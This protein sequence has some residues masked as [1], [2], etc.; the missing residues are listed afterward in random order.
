MKIG[1]LDH[2]QIGE[3]KTAAIALAESVRLAQETER[4]GYGRFWVSEHHGSKALAA[5][6]PE[7]MIAHLAAATSRIRVG[8]GGIMLTH[9]SAYKVAENFRLLEA[10]HP[11]RIDLGLGR[12]PGGMPIATRAL[13]EGKHYHIDQY[14]QQIAD[15][16]AYLH[17]A[18]PEGHR[19]AGLQ[20]SPSL[21]T[22][23]DMWLLGSSGESAMIAARQGLAFA[24]AQFFGA[25]GGEEAIRQYKQHFQP[26]AVNPSP[27]TMIAVSALCADT[28]E[29]AVRLGRS[30]ELF[31]LQLGK[32][33][34]LPWFPSEETAARHPYTPYDEAEIRNRR[35]SRCAGT[36]EV[37][38][39]KLLQLKER[40]GADELMVV[41][42]VHD[43]EARLRSVRL[44]AEA[45]GLTA[46]AAEA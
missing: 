27:R 10:L 37:V 14:P 7:V 6:S 42:P 12:A 2:V 41:T 26:S 33:K 28:E 3:G 24:F 18:L 40:Y 44:L 45:F 31:F 15:L 23:P 38:R 21:P 17:D 43:F 13:Q 29:E 39:E 32:G 11:G 9:Y 19:F 16:T 8:S 34:E 35:H 5:S 36:P 20:A 25:P 22:A 1:F 46:A 4:L 30:S